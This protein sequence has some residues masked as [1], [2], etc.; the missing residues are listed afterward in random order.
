MALRLRLDGVSYSYPLPGRDEAPALQDIGLEVE[1][2]QV[3]CLAGS[4]G[5]GKSTLAQVCAGLLKPDSG[6]L[7]YG[8][9]KVSGRSALRDFRSRVGLL[10]Q[11]PEDQL[12]A[13]TVARDIAFGPRNQGLRDSELEDRVCEAAEYAG[14]DLGSLGQRSVFSLSGGEQRRAALAGV[15]AL[16]PELLVL[17]EPFIGLDYEGRE[18]LES[19]VWRYRRE[20]EASIILVTHELSHVWGLADGFGLLSG[21]RLLGVET[22]DTI[23]TTGIDL[24]SLGMQLPQWGAIARELLRGGISVEDP[25]DPRAL[26]GALARRREAARGDD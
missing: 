26:A 1:P 2:G 14:L 19:A 7:Y 16:K 4:N 17:D 3:L 24:A 10:F 11:N 12:F 23:M 18:A 8:E 13:D 6:S 22:R 25:A 9:G 5:S 21:G 15:F 20:K